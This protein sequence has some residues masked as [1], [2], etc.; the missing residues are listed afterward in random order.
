[1]NEI[2]LTL[3]FLKLPVPVR[4]VRMY[5]CFLLRQLRSW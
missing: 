1:L 5:Y 3:E 2:A 4:T